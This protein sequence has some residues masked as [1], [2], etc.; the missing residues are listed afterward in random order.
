MKGDTKICYRLGAP[1]S[2]QVNE[3]AKRHKMTP[4]QYARLV[5]VQHF[6]NA[7]TLDLLEGLEALR[8]EVKVFHSAFNAALE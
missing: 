3:S 2:E 1:Y 8:D 4:H 6:E 5:L 7:Q